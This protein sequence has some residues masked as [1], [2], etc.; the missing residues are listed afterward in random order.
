MEPE[1]EFD[2]RVAQI[3][4]LS[5][6]AGFGSAVVNPADSRHA[7]LLALVHSFLGEGYD[8]EKVAA[9][10]TLH[11]ELASRQ[12]ALVRELQERRIGPDDYVRMLNASAYHVFEEMKDVLGPTDFD[13]LF[14]PIPDPSVGFVDAEAFRHAHRQRSK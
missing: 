5:E 2:R 3:H 14:G 1:D 10:E 12:T 13:K 11:A 8:G 6:S 9:L 4:G 7:E